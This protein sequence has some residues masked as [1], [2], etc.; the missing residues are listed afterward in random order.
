MEVGDTVD[1]PISSRVRDRDESVDINRF[2]K[3]NIYTFSL[4]KSPH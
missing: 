4:Q 1:G 3:D 2:R